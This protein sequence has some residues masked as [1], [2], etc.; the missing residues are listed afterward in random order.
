MTLT[1]VC[2]SKTQQFSGRLSLGDGL[3]AQL[4]ATPSS[5]VSCSPSVWAKRWFRNTNPLTHLLLRIVYGS[6]CHAR[7][8]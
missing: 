7:K 2:Y 1:A 8:A 6:H 4:S 5:H 3:Q